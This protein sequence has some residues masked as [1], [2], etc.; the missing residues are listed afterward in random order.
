MTSPLKPG[1]RVVVTCGESRIVGTVMDAKPDWFD[2]RADRADQSNTFSYRTGWSFSRLPD[3]VP[4]WADEVGAVCRFEYHGKLGH[5]WR[6]DACA[7]ICKD[8]APHDVGKW[9]T[10]AEMCAPYSSPPVLLWPTEG[11]KD[12]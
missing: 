2:V 5:L 3:P 8:A 1:D 9:Q 4:W 12:E 6:R 10:F 11:A 7:W